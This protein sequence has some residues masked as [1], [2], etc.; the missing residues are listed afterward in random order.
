MECFGVATSAVILLGGAAIEP[1]KS[2]VIAMY[3]TRILSS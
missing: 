2:E 3:R 1:V